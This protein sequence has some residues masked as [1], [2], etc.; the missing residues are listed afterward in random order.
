MIERNVSWEVVDLFRLGIEQ[1]QNPF[2]LE[3]ADPGYVV[4][5]YMLGW[6]GVRAVYEVLGEKVREGSSCRFVGTYLRHND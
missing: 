1:A 2:S 5:W 4:E 6:I 3:A